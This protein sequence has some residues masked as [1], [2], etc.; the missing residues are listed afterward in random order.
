MDEILEFSQNWNNKLNCDSFTAVRLHNPRKYCVGAVKNIYLKG[1][2]KGAATIIDVRQ[3]RL[4]Q[5]NNFVSQLDT[6]LAV[7]PFRQMI[8]E[9]YKKQPGVNW[10]TQLLDLCLLRYNKESKEPK[11]NF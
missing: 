10:D 9:L 4:D 7:E 3:V 11:L 8:R 1:I 2:W 6:G 5:L